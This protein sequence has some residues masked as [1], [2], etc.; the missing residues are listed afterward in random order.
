MDD[1]T[2]ADAEVLDAEDNTALPTVIPDASLSTDILG[3]RSALIARH[4]EGARSF[5]DN[6]K[7]SGGTGAELTIIGLVDEVIKESDHLLGNELI[8]TQN[9]NL[10]DASVI[11]FKRAEVLEKAIR[12]IQSKREFERDNGKGIDLTS[13]TMEVVFRF[14]LN[15]VKETFERIGAPSEMTDLFFRTM[16][17][18]TQ[19]WKKELAAMIDSNEIPK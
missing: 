17:T 19:D 5:L 15:K 8:A 12:A 7:K 4:Y 9:G 11:S 13:P 1:F 18:V 2:K 3:L 14:F 16:E 10:R 6:L